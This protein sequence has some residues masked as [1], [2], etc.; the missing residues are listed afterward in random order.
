[1]QKSPSK[2][3]ERSFGV[4][5]VLFIVS[6]HKWM[7]LILALL[8]LG[9]AVAVYLKQKPLYQSETKLL[10]RY[11]MGIGSLDTYDRTKSP[12]G[13]GRSH[14]PVIINEMEMLSSVDLATE[15]A[16]AIGIKKLLPDSK[17]P[18]SPSDAARVITS[19]LL[20]DFDKGSSVLRV[21]YK[22][23]NPELSKQVL[24][25]LV[26]RY[27]TK[28]LEI[29]RSA[30]A[31]DMASKQLEEVRG[32][33]VRTRRELIRIRSELIMKMHAAQENK[34]SNDLVQARLERDKQQAKISAFRQG[35]G[36]PNDDLR[37]LKNE[38]V[39]CIAKVKVLE[40]NMM[41]IQ[42][43]LHPNHVEL[44]AITRRHQMEAAEYRSLEMKL[45]NA[46]TNQTLDPSRRPNITMVQQ[47]TEPVKVPDEFTTKLVLGLAVG[48][49][50][51]GLGIAFLLELVF[52]RR[53]ERPAEIDPSK[54]TQ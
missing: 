53:I 27:F 50:A 21:N 22:N 33:L 41:E 36:N 20:V 17:G 52:N 45:K 29:Q 43:M 40:D 1:M 12:D 46:R 13:G 11:V 7:I 47:P 3:H 24:R 4:Q 2:A 18:V 54:S 51:L 32:R 16:S 28:H 19:N 35:I 10:V 39:S 6:K 15:V 44:E 48:G 26:E 30:A 5:D 38:L 25:E 34:V 23:G 37:D 49:L 8:G 42:K 31:F 14:D 9:A